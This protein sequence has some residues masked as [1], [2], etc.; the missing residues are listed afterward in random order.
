[1]SA[2]CHG[3]GD[4]RLLVQLNVTRACNLR[5]SHCYIATQTKETSG[6]IGLDDALRVVDSACALSVRSARPV[7][8]SIIGGEP[9]L[10]G[11]A[12]F[13]AF[14]AGVAQRATASGADLSLILV[15]NLATSRALSIAK[16]FA[17]VATSWDPTTRFL[18]HD[19][20]P[21]PGLET[22]W[23]R[24]LSALLA[25]GV[26]TT[27]TS[28]VTRPLIAFGAPRAC[29]H[30]QSLGVPMVSFTFLVP[31]GDAAANAGALLPAFDETSRFL[32]EAGE[33]WLASD[34]SLAVQPIA[35]ALSSWLGAGDSFDVVCPIVSGSLSVDFDG[36]SHPCLES[37]SGDHT[38]ERALWPNAVRDGLDAALRHPL[39]L[40]A[41]LAASVGHPACAPCEFRSRCRS[42]C[43]V[44]ARHWKPDT[45]PDCPGF[46]GF[47]AWARREA[48][49]LQAM[50][51]P[52]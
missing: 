18:A 2:A 36:V 52:S 19:G 37:G 5:C 1:M 25:S 32:I 42:G 28:V 46:R 3:T 21:R 8:L 44:L 12:W 43:G 22:A 50:P 17:Q 41:R 39:V 27:V 13:D 48:P 23:Q 45:D 35:G 40:R 26:E 51:R 30:L 4:A 14:L 6:M 15:T 24:R 7:S 34:G 20:T 33:W 38:H 31:S 9:T 29:E 47:H 16:C 49:R 10:L 11:P